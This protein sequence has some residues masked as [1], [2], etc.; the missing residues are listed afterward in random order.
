MPGLNQYSLIEQSL[1]LFLTAIL[2]GIISPGLSR[3]FEVDPEKSDLFD[4]DNNYYVD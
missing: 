3:F 4:Q 2:K 1:V